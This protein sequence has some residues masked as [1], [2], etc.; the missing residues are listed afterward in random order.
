MRGAARI[1]F[2]GCLAMVFLLGGCAS[3]RTGEDRDDG[4]IQFDGTKVN[5]WPLCY[6]D[7]DRLTILW[8]VFSRNA[9]GLAFL[10]GYWRS[11]SFGVFPLFHHGPDFRY[12][13]PLWFQPPLK[14]G[15]LFPVGW[16]T[17]GLSYVVPAW[18]NRETGSWGVVPA[19]G[20]SSTFNHV[21]LAWWNRET[22]SWGVVP[23]AG[24]SSTFNHVALAWWN[25][26][27]RSG[28]LFPLIWMDFRNG[29]FW[30][31][32]LSR[33]VVGCTGGDPAAAGEMVPFWKFF[34]Y[35]GPVWWSLEG[36]WGVFP[37]GMRGAEFS[38]LG[39]VWWRTREGVTGE[40]GVFPLSYWSDSFNY[41][42]PLWWTSAGSRGFFPVLWQFPQWGFAGPVWWNVPSGTFGLFPL[43][44]RG[45]ELSWVGPAWWKRRRPGYGFFP[46]FWRVEGENA[47]LPFYFYRNSAKE[48]IL[49]LGTILWIS[50]SKPERRDPESGE[51]IAPE[52]VG[53]SCLWPLWIWRREGE[54]VSFTLWPLVTRNS[55]ALSRTLFASPVLSLEDEN[56]YFLCGLGYQRRVDREPES[57]L[58]TSASDPE[59]QIALYSSSCKLVS[60][61]SVILPLLSGWESGRCRVWRDG[62]DRRRLDRI[63]RALHRCEAAFLRERDCRNPDES[64]RLRI[65]A[66][67][68]ASRKA[69]AKE[70][71]FLS[72]APPGD[73]ES[74]ETL[75]ETI[76]QY[77]CE[78]R[79][80]FS[81]DLLP[82]LLFNYVR[83]GG[84]WKMNT[85]LFHA[86]E[87]D[88][89]RDVSVL[90]FLY[91][92]RRRGE[93]S[94]YQLPGFLYQN[95]PERRRISVL[96]GLYEHE[97]D[98]GRLRGK[99]FW[100][101][102]GE[103]Q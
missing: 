91:Q 100:F 39:P 62:V 51:V 50:S 72:L 103:D 13:G 77:Y 90:G 83:C 89:D 9:E 73:L 32:P 66:E 8:P 61:E 78:D 26:N 20:F 44:G 15:G 93:S 5:L 19:A 17:P 24:F 74:C 41:V 4:A 46:L 21:A 67:V 56:V 27:S 64:F 60:D 101:P 31:F 40:G 49:N 45:K 88:G 18:W 29:E 57:S 86:D 48:R 92:E 80:F 71:R 6:A 52:Q 95:S 37:L 11:G 99:L 16:F 35:V 102:W 23:A 3:L 87:I 1:V 7:R 25:R 81:L 43:F 69:L 76:A 53:Y 12:Y 70:L 65:R 55:S 84:D 58:P 47:L 10:N 28:G 34:S 79:E 98:H 22:G 75:A 33:L 82:L 30:F 94:E 68:D 63:V 2:S 59:R 54:E 36:S 14:R 85:C 38:N 97:V 42:G 96:F